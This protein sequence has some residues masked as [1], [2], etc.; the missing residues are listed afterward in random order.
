MFK[1]ICCLVS[2]LFP[3]PVMAEEIKFNNCKNDCFEINI[4]DINE[5]WGN[6]SGNK[7]KKV[8][9]LGQTVISGLVNFNG[10]FNKPYYGDVVISGIN[11]RGNPESNSVYRTMDFISSIENEDQTKIYE[12]YYENQIKNFYFK[13]GK[14]DFSSDFGFDGLTSQFL[15]ASMFSSMVINN[16]TY[17]MTNYGPSSSPGIEIDYKIKNYILKYGVASDNPYK[18]KFNEN[19]SNMN[20]DRYGTDMNFKS[21]IM[22]FEIEKDYKNSKYI[23]GGFYDFGRQANTYTN[24]FHKVDYSYY[25]TINQEIFKNLYAFSR[26]MIAPKHNVTNINYTLDTGFVFK[27]SFGIAGSLTNENKKVETKYKNHNEY[28]IELFYRYNFTNQNFYIQPDIQYIIH[29]SADYKNE[30][31]TGIRTVYNF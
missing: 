25:V 20:L 28:R 13:I 17:N 27:D 19:F 16:N 5:V 2:L 14:F 30:T 24:N 8:S 4:T 18:G 15:N 11:I 31:I 29:P 1:K 26:F 9:Y 7:N 22:Y 12:F 3:F 6:V 21:P 10:I 23:I